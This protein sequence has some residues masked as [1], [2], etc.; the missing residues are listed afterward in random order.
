MKN[1][2]R[3]R[4]RKRETGAGW[5]QGAE[6]EGSRSKRIIDS[7]PRNCLERGKAACSL[8]ACAQRPRGTGS[9]PRRPALLT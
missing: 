8:K 6:G 7:G 2:G 4:E 3:R 1:G 9:F 5:G